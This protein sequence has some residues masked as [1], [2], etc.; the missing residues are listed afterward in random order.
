MKAKFATLVT[1]IAFDGSAQVDLRQCWIR[2]ARCAVANIQ[3]MSLCKRHG[4]YILRFLG[5][6][7]GDDSNH[8]VLRFC[9]P[10][11]LRI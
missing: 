3:F 2:V 8:T 4:F 9:T 11:S 7:F 1:A 10:V 5:F 6:V